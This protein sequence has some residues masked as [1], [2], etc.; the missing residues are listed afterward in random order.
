MSGPFPE[1]PDSGVFL[2]PGEHTPNNNRLYIIDKS[3]VGEIDNRQVYGGVGVGNSQ[4]ETQVLE[5][6]SKAYPRGME[7]KRGVFS[8]GGQQEAQSRSVRHR[9]SSSSGIMSPPIEPVTEEDTP[10]GS[11]SFN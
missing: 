8:Q 10:S 3:S 9:S 7:G 2:P 1:Y 5:T 6:R 4:R 11:G